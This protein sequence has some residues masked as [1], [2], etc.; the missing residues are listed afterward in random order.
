MS[1][2]IL[3]QHLLATIDT[4]L[5]RRA[6]EAPFLQHAGLGTL[7]TNVL[8]H[9]LAQDTYYTRA[10]V[11]FI[12]QTLSALRLPFSSTAGAGDSKALDFR[13]L[14]VLVT[15]L[16]GIHREMAF[17]ES[18]AARYGLQLT[19]DGS[20]PE[21]GKAAVEYQEL[22]RAT[23]ERSAHD[24]RDGLLE[25]LVVLW[26]TE[27][28]YL[29]AWR[30]AREGMNAPSSAKQDSNATRALYEAFIPNWTSDEFGSFVADCA[31]VVDELAGEMGV[32]E[33]AAKVKRYQQVWETVL[34][35]EEA[36]W[37]TM[38]L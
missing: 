15:A 5:A 22:F 13:I 25:A 21:P 37:P 33:D 30:K 9:W 18:T 6:F 7:P 23:G 36:F 8:E 19:S 14:D 31:K 20:P 27:H 4:A 32:L 38:E 28:T 17:F 12:G 11:R 29:T 16:N 35:I 2:E 26:A 1:K 10:Y 3:T 34:G 24:G